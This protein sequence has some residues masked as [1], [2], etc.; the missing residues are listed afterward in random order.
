MHSVL[1][2]INSAPTS[3][4]SCSAFQ[5][6]RQMRAQGRAVSIFLAQ[7]AV[8]A[9]MR[10]NQNAPLISVLQ[11]GIATYALSDDLALRGFAPGALRDGVRVADYARL[12][13]L[14]EQHDQV[15]G[16]L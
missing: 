6:A 5:L 10:G 14:F 8:V 7:D 2:W 16:A 4:N 15:I 13:E 3:S 12:V 1:I 11:A 9:G